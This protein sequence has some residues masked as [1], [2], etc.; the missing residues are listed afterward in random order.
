MVPWQGAHRE[1]E[2]GPHSGAAALQEL[3]QLGRLIDGVAA[4]ADE[5]I[6]RDAVARTHESP[7]LRGRRLEL[8]APRSDVGQER[9]ELVDDGASASTVA[10]LS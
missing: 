6:T 2:D 5:E 7:H 10:E 9:L 1:V 8:A 3:R 4:E